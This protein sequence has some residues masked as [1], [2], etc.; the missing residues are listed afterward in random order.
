MREWTSYLGEIVLITAVS[1]LLYTV[2]P[3]GNLKKHLQFVI[4]LC[5]VVALAVPM[6]SMIVDLPEIF[7]KEFEEVKKGEHETPQEFADSLIS[8]S[9]K[10]VEKAL[11]S[12]IAEKYA[13]A[14]TDLSAETVLDAA[15]P[16]SIEIC[17]IKIVIKGEY[18]VSIE[19]I[20]EDLYEM[21]LGKSRVTVLYAE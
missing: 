12:Y 19:K 11:V 13:I 7:E 10:E 2:S 6:F 15:N 20:Q 18:A 16:E 1:G 8:A 4:S 3:E 21:F 9:K 14:E 17:E 5:I